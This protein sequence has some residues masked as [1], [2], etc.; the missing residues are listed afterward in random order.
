L[1]GLTGLVHLVKAF[2]SGD[3]TAAEGGTL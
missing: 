1:C 2:K 3:E